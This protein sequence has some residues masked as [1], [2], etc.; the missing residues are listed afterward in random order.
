MRKLQLGTYY[1]D[2][3][4]D[5]VDEGDLVDLQSKIEDHEGILKEL[6]SFDNL[7]EIKI[8]PNDLEAFKKQCRERIDLQHM[9]EIGEGDFE[10][11]DQYGTFKG[12]I[13]VALI[14]FYEPEPK[15]KHDQQKAIQPELPLSI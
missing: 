8:E 10:T 11:T 13:R 4:G 2:N 9:I 12:T 5:L 6:A 14:W 3:D 1:F 15:K 7:P